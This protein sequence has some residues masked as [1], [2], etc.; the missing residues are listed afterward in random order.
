MA[1]FAGQVTGVSRPKELDLDLALVSLDDDVVFLESSG[2]LRACDVRNWT[3]DSETGLSQSRDRDALR[4]S[5]TWKAR[6][7]AL[8]SM[9]M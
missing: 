1:Q 6:T 4:K 3:D 8:R 9:D 7:I 2:G 5:S